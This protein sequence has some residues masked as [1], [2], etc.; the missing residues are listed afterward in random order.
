VDYDAEQ[1]SR[2]R[3]PRR[4][5]RLS[6]SDRLLIEDLL[7]QAPRRAVRRPAAPQLRSAADQQRIALRG[8]LLR[9]WL[10]RT[11]LIAETL[12]VLLLVGASAYWLADTFLRDRLYEWRRQANPAA[13]PI[14]AAATALP[15]EEAASLPFVLP[16]EDSDVGDFLSEQPVVRPIAGGDPRPQRIEIPTIG[17]TSGIEEVFVV[18]GVW[19]VAEY[20][21]GYHHG[22]A[23]PGTVGNTVLAGHAG[24]RGAVFRDLPLLRSGDEIIVESG[25]WIYTYR[26]RELREVWPTQ[27][28]VMNPTATPVLTLITCTNWDTQR[29]VVVADLIASRPRS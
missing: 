5:A 24:I 13:A 17:L 7:Q 3:A 2:R 25:D 15:V 23:L 21:A 28:E 16:E 18:D 10:D 12:L 4:A 14:T 6:H 29:L 8:F 22:T 1:R 20:A 9:N 27:V 26:V 11:L 19:E